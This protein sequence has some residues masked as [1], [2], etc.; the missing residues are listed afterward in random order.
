MTAFSQ[1]KYTASELTRGVFK[2]GNSF[3]KT[4]THLI[5]NPTPKSELFPYSYFECE[6]DLFYTETGSIGFVFEGDPISGMDESFYKQLSLIFDDALEEGAF[7]QTLLL[8]SD[9]LS[10]QLSL[11]KKARSN[12]SDIAKS[13]EESKEKFYK[14]YNNDKERHF[15]HRNYRLFFIYSEKDAHKDEILSFK[16]KLESILRAL[17]MDVHALNGQDFLSLTQDLVSYG[18]TKKPV[19]NPHELLS[20]SLVDVSQ[21]L[22]VTERDLL[23]GEEYVSRLYE[24][25]EGRSD[26]SLE[27][28]PNLIGDTDNESLNLPCRFALSYTIGNSLSSAKQESFKIKGEMAVKQGKGVMARFNKSCEDEALE[29]DSVLN[30]NLKRRERFLKSQF[31]VLLTARKDKIEKAEQN[32]ISLFKKEDMRIS[33]LSYF[34]LPALLSLCPF[35]MTEGLSGL[36]SHFGL[37]KTCLSSEPKA[38]MPIACEWKGGKNGGQLF[39]GRRG[40]LFAWDSFERGSNYNVCVVGESGSGKSVFLQDFVCSHLARGARVFVVDIG[41]SF[42]KTCEI[43]G[44]DFLEFQSDSNISLNPF[45]QIREDDKTLRDES[46]SLL[47]TVIAKMVAPKAGTEDIQDA[48]ISKSLFRAFLEDGQNTTLDT[49]SE[50]IRKD[51]KRGEDLATML[52]EFT[53]KGSYGKF[54]SGPSTISF[55]NDL[56][57]LEFEE[58]RERP[59]L[60]AVIMQ[61]LALQILQQVYLGDRKRRFL[62]L[63]DE[64]WY[65]LSHF[66]KM[67]ESMARTVRKYNG[68]LI[69]GTQSLNDFYTES[70]T[71]TAD[72]RARMSVIENSAWRVLLK[73]KSASAETAKKLGFDSHGIRLIKSLHT[74][75][76]EYS[77]ALI[78]QSEREYFV[79]RLMLDNFSQVLYSSHPGIFSRIQS[80]KEK[81][82]S[83]AEAINTIALEGL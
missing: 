79:G 40:Q 50:A 15:L 78:C 13:L 20:D 12:K 7:L 70:D 54:F 42:Q 75:D 80:Y 44:G 10:P 8:A 35:L 6:T 49:L 34:H 1:L 48:L 9:D 30:D 31:T 14:N 46:L 16:D 26:F 82:L 5:S 41:R 19:Y 66:P 23:H 62:I 18:S 2:S 71:V 52:F 74:K 65:A 24:T 83:T 36:L 17:K 58:L 73:Q 39:T 28:I 4:V 32:L 61:M 51:G 57:V 22:R 33:P 11:W 29:W 21:S 45:S 37:L 53:E 55:K 43:L 56:T 63:F 81:G 77:E 59:E 3:L 25:H 38:L 72:D 60:G 69:L 76:K 64:A 27:R 68:S 47:K 67:L